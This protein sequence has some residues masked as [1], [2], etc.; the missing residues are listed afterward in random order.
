[1]FT[2]KSCIT[3]YTY[4]PTT[5]WITKRLNY[6]VPAR[7]IDWLNRPT[8]EPTNLLFVNYLNKRAGQK[9]SLERMYLY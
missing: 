5:R 1:M 2:N 3:I 7:P 8:E 6:S 9:T 4:T